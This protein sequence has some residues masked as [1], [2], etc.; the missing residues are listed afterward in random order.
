[1]SKTLEESFKEWEASIYGLD[2]CMCSYK[3]AVGIAANMHK[4]LRARRN[5]IDQLDKDGTQWTDRKSERMRVFT[6][7]LTELDKFLMASAAVDYK[8][9]YE[10]LFWVKS[11]FCLL[12]TMI[13]CSTTLFY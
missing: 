9:Y 4:S 1:M 3:C 12:G 11:Y 2:S 7:L 6:C 5:D 13:G 8:R 10:Q